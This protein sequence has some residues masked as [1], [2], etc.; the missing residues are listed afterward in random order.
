MQKIIKRVAIYIR[1]STDEN[2]SN[3]V[4]TKAQ[5]DAI[6]NYL[7]RNNDLYIYDRKHIYIDNW[8]SWA[9]DDRPAL[10][11][12][13]IAAEN[14]EFDIVFVWKI[15]RF[16]RKLLY[17]LKEVEYLND[18]WIWL[19]SITQEID[20]SWPAWKFFLQ[21]MWMAWELERDNIRERTISWRAKKALDWFYVWGS[22][23]KYWYD[24]VATTWWKKLE[25]NL[26]EKKV[27]ERIFDMFTNEKLSVNKI[28]DILTNEKIPTKYDIFVKDK[29]KNRKAIKWVWHAWTV[30]RLLK[31]NMY[32]WEY[33][34]WRYWKRKDPITK[35]MISYEKP[36][37]EWSILPCPRILENNDIFYKAQELLETNK[38]TKNNPVSYSF[39]SLLICKECWKHYN[40]Y[41]TSK[42]TLSYRCW[43]SIRWKNKWQDLCKNN[44]ISEIYLRDSIWNKV[45]ELFSNPK[46][47]LESYYNDRNQND[48]L[49]ILNSELLEI[50]SNIN[51]FKN[52][53]SNIYDDYY[54]TNWVEREILF[55]KIADFKT[56]ISLYEERKM[57]INKRITKVSNIER[58]KKSFSLLAKSYKQIFNKLDDNQRNEIIKEF[59]ERINIYKWW[60]L[61]VLFRFWID[62]S[63]RNND[64]WNNVKNKGKNGR[65]SSNTIPSLISKNSWFY[66]KAVYSWS[67]QVS[68]VTN[69]TIC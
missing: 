62:K 16:F 57:W 13:R 6:I 60:K 15:D 7:D 56:K 30:W 44:E 52:W 63:L 34:Y 10:N 20:T 12:M 31:N 9:S 39:T 68:G 64:D 61:D 4:S 37:E 17:L 47:I 19:K 65:D 18:L 53:L 23:P 50:D 11:R 33:Y 59:V 48:R 69:A 45:F 25:V 66:K 27:I 21:M 49:N 43:W 2:V 3:W 35:K 24:S 38:I 8:E 40:W 58:N 22:T 54:T 5:E 51:K 42:W 67:T 32:I 36:K 41:K 26:D 29:N 46:E 14:K 28:S 55:E 1:V